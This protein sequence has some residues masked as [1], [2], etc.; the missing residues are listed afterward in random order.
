MSERALGQVLIEAK[1]ASYIQ[2][3]Q[4]SVGSMQEM[5]KVKI[6]EGFIFDTVPGLSLEVIEKLKRFNPPTLFAA[7]EISGITPASLDVL[8]LYIHLRGKES[9]D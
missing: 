9:V 4:E 5:L 2:K 7:S 8:H 3:Q 6:P 1:Y